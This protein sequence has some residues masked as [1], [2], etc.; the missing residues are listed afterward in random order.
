MLFY[1]Q[2]VYAD[3]I[4]DNRLS[5]SFILIFLFLFGV[6]INE[7]QDQFIYLFKIRQESDFKRV[8]GVMFLKEHVNFLVQRFDECQ[9]K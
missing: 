7:V 6:K 4:S 3:I 8:S 5:F 1:A 2:Q 9:G